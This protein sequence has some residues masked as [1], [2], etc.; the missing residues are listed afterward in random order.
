MDEKRKQV[1]IKYLETK[2]IISG[3][4]FETPEGWISPQYE[5]RQKYGDKWVDIP[6]IDLMLGGS[7]ERR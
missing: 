2:E 1:I 7:N 5:W 6:L 3:G 4:K